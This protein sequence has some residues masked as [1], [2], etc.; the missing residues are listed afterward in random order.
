MVVREKYGGGGRHCGNGYGGDPCLVM[1]GGGALV[2]GGDLWME[3]G[4]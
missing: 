1:G 4:G 2:M 3:N